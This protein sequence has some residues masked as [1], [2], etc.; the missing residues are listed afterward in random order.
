MCD[1]W[2]I[3]AV[4]PI[5]YAIED[6]ALVTGLNCK[7]GRQTSLVAG[8]IKENRKIAEQDDDIMDFLREVL[9]MLGDEEEFLNHPWGRESFLCYLAPDRVRK[10]SRRHGWFR[11]S[12]SSPTPLP[13]A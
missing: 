1:F 10:D 13:R 12:S 9:G 5:R 7:P 4:K 11:N 6:F 3:F 8:N 2:R